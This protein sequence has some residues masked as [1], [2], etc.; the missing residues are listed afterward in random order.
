[1]DTKTITAPVVKIAQNK[2]V[3]IVLIAIVVLAFVYYLGRKLGEKY[4]PPVPY[5]DGG[6]S[7]PV[8][9]QRQGDALTDQCRVIL[10]G[11]G[12]RSDERDELFVSLFALSNDQLTYVY[13]AWNARYYKEKG[14]SLTQAIDDI[15]VYGWLTGNKKKIVNRLKSLGL[16]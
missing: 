7:L 6:N 5:P 2:T 12:K 8:D 9:W 15:I 13:N 11:L 3:Q 14:D 4:I 1:M 16:Y 10:Y